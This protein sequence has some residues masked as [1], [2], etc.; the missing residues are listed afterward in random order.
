MSYSWKMFQL[1]KFDAA[2]SLS[3]VKITEVKQ[4]K[5]FQRLET[6]IK[7]EQ[8]WKP[9]KILFE[10]FVLVT[11][12]DFAGFLQDV[13]KMSKKTGLDIKMFSLGILNTVEPIGKNL[14]LKIK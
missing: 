13:K 12:F 7:I 1:T 2:L 5:C 10:F 4:R 6:R 8:C 9:F 14:S 3:M 11:S